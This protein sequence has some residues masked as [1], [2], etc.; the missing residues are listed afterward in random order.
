M[1]TVAIVEDDD[2]FAATLDSYIRR[3]VN[4]T[5][6]AI[7][8][9]RYHDGTQ[10][11]DSYQGQYQIVLMDV[12]MP[13]MNGLEVAKHLRSRD[14]DVCLIFITN[15]VQYA[16]HG[17]EVDAIDYVLKPLDY[18]LFRIKFG[19]AVAR[20]HIDEKFTIPLPGGART[21]SFSRI[22]YVESNKHYVHLHTTEG[23]FRMRDT[24]RNLAPRF[25]NNGFAAI[26]ASV[27]INMAYVTQVTA[28]DVVLGDIRLPVARTYRADFRERLT[29]FL[30]GG[31]ISEV[32]GDVANDIDATITSANE[33]ALDTA[34]RTTGNSANSANGVNGVNSANSVD[35][36]DNTGMIPQ[37]QSSP[38]AEYE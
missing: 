13:H 27:L 35:N 26:R 6:R 22:I 19:K 17:Y 12:V 24:V 18:D 10:F 2:E 33:F 31:V 37:C 30:S 28:G 3:Y 34:I 38:G 20:V 16:I 32:T 29:V 25:L 9:D 4:E 36:A 21:I 11:L 23:E 1:L 5:H 15:M 8:I 7:D 14:R